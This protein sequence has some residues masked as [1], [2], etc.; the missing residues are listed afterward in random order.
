[1]AAQTRRLHI[2]IT[3]L[4]SQTV[5]YLQRFI[6]EF[7]EANQE[8]PSLLGLQGQMI[9]HGDYEANRKKAFEVVLSEKSE[10]W[11]VKSEKCCLFEQVEN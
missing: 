11:K 4:W 2:P 1:M 8:R 3:T 9:F 7:T 10:K 5:L 6:D